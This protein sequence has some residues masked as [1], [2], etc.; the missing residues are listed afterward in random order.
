MLAL[1]PGVI[2]FFVGIDGL[3]VWLIVLTTLLL[4]ASVL[5]SWKAV[6]ERVNEFHAWLLALEAGLIGVFVS[7]DVI[8]FYVFFELTLVPLFFLIGIWGGPE[9]QYAARKFFVYT[10]AGSLITLL[11]VLG[12]VLTLY[13]SPTAAKDTPRRL[14]FSIPELVEKV[15]VLNAE[16]PKAVEADRKAWRDTNDALARAPE[17]AR[18]EITRRRDAAKV[19]MEESQKRVDFW[20]TVQMYAFAAMMVGFAIKVPLVPVHT[21]LPLA[22]VEAPT[23]GSVLLAG[24]LLKL[25]SYGF[26]RLCLPLTPDASL[27][28]G[29]P[30][31]GTL[32]VIGILYGATCAIAQEDMKKLVAY[33]SVSHMGLCLLGLFALNEMGLTGSLLQMINHGLSTGAM[34][35]LV[36]MLYER[37]HTRKLADYG[38]MG[39]K[40]KLLA[41]F[42]VF[43]GMSG[44]GLPGLNGFIGEVLVLFGMY[45]FQ[46]DFSTAPVNGKLLV[47]LASFGAVLGAWYTLTLIMRVFFGPLKEPPHGGHGPAD[48]GEHH[49]S[50]VPDLNAREVFTILPIAALCL[51]IGMY[52]QPLLDSIRPDVA[53]VARIAQEARQRA[54]DV[55]RGGGGRLDAGTA[56]AAKRIAAPNTHRRL[57]TAVK[58]DL[59]HALTGYITA[60]LPEAILGLAA[61]V[62]FLGGTWLHCRMRWGIWALVS[63]A[64]AGVAL[65][66]N[67]LPLPGMEPK[68]AA[69]LFAGPVWFDRFSLLVRVVAI[70][71]G[72]VL[73]LLSWDE[74]PD[75][76]AA[77]YHGCLLLIVAG[78]GLTAAANDLITLFLALELVSIPTYVLLYLPRADA[79][80]QEAAMKY[81][82]LSVFSSA[83]LLFGFSYLYGL[84]GT[85]NLP[86]IAEALSRNP[87][88]IPGMSLVALVMVVAG[89][90]FKI[91]AVPFH[92]YAPDVYQGTATANAAVLA[93]VPKVAGFA[94]LVRV[95]GFLPYTFQGRPLTEGGTV[96]L[97]L[98]EQVPV[99]LWI[100]AAVTMT[101]G[102]VLA[103]LQDNLKRLLAYSSVA[104]AGYMLIGLSVAP[105]LAADPNSPVGGVEAMLFYLVAYGG[106]TVGAFAVLSYLSTKERPVETVD[107]LAGLSRSHP[108]VALL[109]ALFLFSLIGI[110]LTA[111]FAGKFLLF[112]GALLVPFNLDNPLSLE[113]RKLFI[114]LAFIAAINAA[115]GGWYYLRV[116]AAMYLRDPLTPIAKGHIRPALFAAWACG[117][118]TLAAGVYPEPLKQAAVDAVGRVSALPSTTAAVPAPA[119]ALAADV[120]P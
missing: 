40:L 102:N 49:E 68:A 103:L 57:S 67:P 66:V 94:A 16:L 118:L 87:A 38:G 80:A 59:M 116:V 69:V 34:F 117:L 113:Q 99:L 41:A 22:H 42:M 91:T 12:V 10:L 62:L 64:A 14:T 77:D 79:P 60:C 110:P 13:L 24:V 46:G 39:A 61:C 106:M 58:E 18:D 82:L 55:A 76:Q 63:L 31:I 78:T 107:D 3:N 53:V 98:G 17:A 96:G 70:V 4:V 44:I 51:F 89:L 88:A 32:A 48:A 19:R 43:I 56:P 25:G 109:M 2:Q 83:F 7:F 11:G 90:G 112:N 115:I 105:R 101:L 15:R 47:T 104:H 20:R 120:R 27:A 100:M 54:D 23:A 85:T 111:G 5:V 1:G 36:G 114:T 8:L 81:F 92:F 86:A 72:A 52:P 37:Y 93:F 21:W 84:A 73:V 95:L 6:T 28:L 74:V 75:R 45:D 119:E 33:S 35:L 30:L 108:G 50:A 29:V 71:G 97:M 9:R 65:A 26:L